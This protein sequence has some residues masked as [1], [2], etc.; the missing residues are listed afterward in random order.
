MSLSETQKYVWG[1]AN[2]DSSGIIAVISDSLGA[3]IPDGVPVTFSTNL[4]FFDNGTKTITT[5]TSGGTAEVYL[6]SENVNNVIKTAAITVVAGVAQSGT[7][8]GS[9]S[10][11][12]YP[13]GCRRCF[14]CLC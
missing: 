2:R 4:G 3:A 1:T 6:V 14:A 7:I 11:R 8:T 5:L 9:T 13:G 12:M 10:L